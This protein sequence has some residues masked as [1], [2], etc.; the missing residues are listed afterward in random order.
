MVDNQNQGLFYGR[1]ALKALTAYAGGIIIGQ[2]VL[3]LPSVFM[4][5]AIGLALTALVFHYRQKATISALF[6][7]SALFVCGIAQYDFATSGF[8][9]THIKNI[10]ESGSRVT[11]VGEIVQEPD[12]RTEKVYLVVDVDSLRWRKRDLNSSGKILVKINQFTS[13]FSYKDR[14]IFKGYL[15]APGGPRNPGG[16]DFAR[17]LSIKEIFGMVVLAGS[18]DIK[19]V[20]KPILSWWQKINAWHLDGLF[21]NNMVAPVRK[22]LLNGYH[23][24]LPPDQASLLAGFVLG[25]KRDIPDEI[26]RLFTDTGTLHLMAVS[27]S[28][29]AIVVIFF[30]TILSRLDRRL[31][32]IITLVA[33]IFFSFLTRNEPSVVR[34]SVMAAVGLIGYYRQKNADYIGLLGFAGLLLLVLNPLWLF[35]VGFQLSF[36]ACAGILYFLPKFTIIG[37]GST[38]ITKFIRWVL[39]IFFTTVAAQIAVLPLT[40]EYFNRLPLVGILANLPMVVLANI[41]TIAGICFLPFI[42]IGD[43][44]AVLFAWPLSQVMSIILPML[45]F[46]MS[47]PMAVINISPPGALKICLL[48]SF[49][50]VSFELLFARR[51]SVKGFTLLSL[52]LI[53]LTVTSYLKNPESDWLAFIDC[54]PDRVALYSD[55]KT[56]VYL[57]YDCHEVGQCR[58]ME[59]SLL[60][61]L[62]KAGVRH[63]DTVFTNNEEKISNLA[64]ELRIG[65]I[66]QP[67]EILIIDSSETVENPPYF[68]TE[69]ILN[70]RVKYVAIKSDNNIETLTDGQFYK[71]STSGG[72]CVLAGGIAPHFA[73]RI[74]QSSRILELP[75]TVQPFGPV[76]ESI[77]KHPPV[78]LVF[79]PNKGKIATVRNWRALTY[80]NE[81]TWATSITGSFRFRFEGRQIFADYM[82]KLNSKG[83]L[84]R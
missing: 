3:V 72:E 84:S 4:A 40:A 34:A 37:C 78:L 69:S 68:F 64:E 7:F 70:K 56:G 16:F 57:W 39:F 80:L 29:V 41:L 18:N 55:P 17:Y 9:P 66:L 73:N 31:R 59:L 11:I 67:N 26:A 10:A 48:F 71:L 19:I 51:F 75:W 28:N 63:I 27:G 50:Y 65:D 62:F 20:E 21:I 46:F 24:Y 74:G 33:V 13:A 2:Y 8:P 45:D 14:I 32:I 30:M 79:S 42:L 6:L 36:A 12:I 15:F 58:Q 61:Y 35:N 22:V 77:R 52:S 5:F 25:E 83:E 60:P 53:A 82:I 49:L 1:P 43:S 47:L 23:E 44:L 54:G 76:F 81:R 38:F